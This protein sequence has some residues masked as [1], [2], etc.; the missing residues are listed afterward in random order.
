MEPTPLTTNQI[1]ILEKH[2]CL[3]AVHSPVK[4]I[5]DMSYVSLDLA[6]ADEAF[7]EL[8]EETKVFAQVIKLTTKSVA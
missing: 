3:K 2:H 8:T 5:Q 1:K 6:R 7:K 4:D